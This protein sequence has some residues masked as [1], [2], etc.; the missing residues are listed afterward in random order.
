ML[1][2][3]EWKKL[4]YTKYSEIKLLRSGVIVFLVDIL[5]PHHVLMIVLAPLM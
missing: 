5:D 2:N 3:T 1:I 4:T